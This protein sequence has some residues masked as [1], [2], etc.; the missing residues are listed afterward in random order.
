[1]EQSRTCKAARLQASGKGLIQLLCPQVYKRERLT[2][3]IGML[4][5]LS[6]MF[7][8]IVPHVA[9][10]AVLQAVIFVPWVNLNTTGKFRGHAVRQC[11]GLLQVPAVC[12]GHLAHGGAWAWQVVQQFDRLQACCQAQGCCLW[13]LSAC[14][15]LVLPAERLSGLQDLAGDTSS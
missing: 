2:C 7:T 4:T 10:L 1:M 5:Q 3:G 8:I 15:S 11:T 6:A 13:S 9:V 14:E 12:P